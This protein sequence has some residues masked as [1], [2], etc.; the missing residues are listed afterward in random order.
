MVR[1]EVHRLDDYVIDNIKEV[2]CVGLGLP[3]LILKVN[4]VDGL[5]LLNVKELAS[6]LI[7]LLL[8]ECASVEAKLDATLDD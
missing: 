6:N 1:L 3:Q 8:A 7:V 2:I 5:L 4:V